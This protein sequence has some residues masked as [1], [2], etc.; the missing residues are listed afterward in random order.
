MYEFPGWGP[1]SK[2]V[3]KILIQTFFSSKIPRQFKIIH[4]PDFETRSK[5]W[6][7]HVFVQISLWKDSSRHICDMIQNSARS[8]Y[9]KTHVEQKSSGCVQNS[10]RIKISSYFFSSLISIL[11]HFEWKILTWLVLGV[12]FWQSFLFSCFYCLQ[13]T[14][15][16]IEFLSPVQIWLYKLSVIIEI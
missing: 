8:S 15:W 3:M 1:R 12:Y 7:V 13:Q 6:C 14:D 2:G 9:E 4:D 10:V 16:N 5:F 11:P